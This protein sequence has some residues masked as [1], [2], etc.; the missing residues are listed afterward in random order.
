M[1]SNI[2]D[3]SLI[4]QRSPDSTVAKLT[5]SQRKK[6]PNSAFAHVRPNGKRLLPINDESHVR[7]A[8]SR[9]SQVKFESD[10]D[11]DTARSRLLRAAK[12]HG[13][14]PVGFIEGQL[15]TARRKAAPGQ[16]IIELGR[17]ETSA[18][19]QTELRRTLDDSTL[20]LLHWSKPEGTYVD[21]DGRPASLPGTNA[22]VQATFLQ[23]SGRP[24]MAIVHDRA[25]LQTPEMT[26]AVMAAVHLVA[27]K[28]L[29]EEI[30]EIGV[31][32]GGLPD[33]EVTFLLTDIEG[34]TQLLSTLGRR[35]PKVL[36]QV[37]TVIREAVLQANG[38][39]VEA[40]AD[41]Y[42]AVFSDASDA[43]VAATEMQ[44]AMRKH[45]WPDGLA[46]KV[47]AGVHTGEIVLTEAGYVGLTV[48]TA[49]RIMAAAHGGQVLISNETRRRMGASGRELTRDLGMFKLR[50]LAPRY[51]L[52]QLEADGLESEFPPPSV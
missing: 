25:V 31:A 18:Q 48:H 23:G 38:R 22:A 26:E 7:N 35:Y 20:W 6:L 43:V 36:T 17:I 24:L 4:R 9:F 50:G 5:A 19:L 52:F 44:R 29:L 49:A 21:C 30:D 46:V 1:I 15:L 41:E 14:V 10:A 47:R 8:L 3:G 37:R 40:R 51:K 33:G 13:I 16:L 45:G 11:R 12:R 32:T 39:Q 42:V 28:E 27:G 2:F 34:S